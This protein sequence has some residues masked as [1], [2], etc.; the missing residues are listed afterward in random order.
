LTYY[1]IDFAR[2]GLPPAAV[3]SG[4]NGPDAF[5]VL[6]GDAITW[7]SPAP[8]TGQ[9][10]PVP[11]NLTVADMTKIYTCQANGTTYN[12]DQFGGKNAPIVPVLP[13]NGS[14]TRATFLAALGHGP[15][16]P[17][18]PGP[19]VVNGVTSGGLPIEENTGVS[20]STYGNTTQF[21]PG[22]TPAVADIFPYSIGDYIAQGS[23][24]G[25]YSGRTIGG[26]TT[27]DFGHG[28]MVLRDSNST[29]PTAKDNTAPYVNAT[30]ISPSFTS[31]LRRI[32]YNV[33]RNGGTATAPKFP[34]SPAY[35]ATALPKI[36]GPT[37][38][39]CTATAAK[40][41]IVSYGFLLEGRNCGAL[42]AGSPC[43]PFDPVC[44]RSRRPGTS[45]AAALNVA[46]RKCSTLTCACA[47]PGQREYQAAV[48]PDSPHRRQDRQRAPR[49][50]RQ[51]EE[52][53]RE[54]LGD[55]H[56][57]TMDRRDR[58]P[59]GCAPGQRAYSAPPG[60]QSALSC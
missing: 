9:T 1:C 34:T 15:N 50:G 21:D 33:V 27:P 46:W 7:S 32:L 60:G 13:Q 29:V 35:E 10:S 18:N 42:S 38:W 59:A 4:T 16:N 19:C 45:G 41:D 48:E 28:V 54:Q 49:T 12:W 40:E 6:G 25:T 39:E 31:A 17:L 36:F 8:K 52:A 5:A 51:L 58:S 20:S 43:W 26:H 22:G 53:E 55:V 3:V 56:N 14:G 44:G 2:T 37:G 23:G 57:I 30:V 11:S 47:S 24:E